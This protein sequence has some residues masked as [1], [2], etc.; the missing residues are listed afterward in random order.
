MVLYVIYNV[1][2][3]PDMSGGVS[4]GSI[5]KFAPLHPILCGICEKFVKPI[6]IESAFS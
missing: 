6:R 5:G 3:K 2:V 1:P 4:H